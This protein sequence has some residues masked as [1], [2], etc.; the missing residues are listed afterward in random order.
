[1][2]TFWAAL[3]QLLQGKP[4]PYTIGDLMS[5]YQHLYEAIGDNA[6]ENPERR[7]MLERTFAIQ[8][9]HEMDERGSTRQ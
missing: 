7:R 9:M 3:E 4:D 6:H 1:M 2:E 5:D 8:N